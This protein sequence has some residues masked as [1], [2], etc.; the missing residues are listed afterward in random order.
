MRVSGYTRNDTGAVVSTDET[1]L[2]FVLRER[3]RRRETNRLRD[4]VTGLRGTV[5]KLMRLMESRVV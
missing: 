4:E 3:E 1:R 2:Q 5:E